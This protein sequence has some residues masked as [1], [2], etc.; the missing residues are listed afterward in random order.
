[1]EEYFLT[2]NNGLYNN[3]IIPDPPYFT[4]HTITTT[5]FIII[6]PTHTPCYLLCSIWQSNTPFLYERDKRL[7]SL[8]LLSTSSVVSAKRHSRAAHPPILH[9]AAAR[10][11]ILLTPPFFHN[12]R[13]PRQ[14]YC[15]T[16]AT[17]DSITAMLNLYTPPMST[18]GPDQRIAYHGYVL[19][20][21][22]REHYLE[23]RER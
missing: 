2:P 4:G 17:Q 11:P 13:H 16:A 6:K 21:K 3:S 23:L 5:S 19:G 8:T 20:A 14:H 12:C 18:T 15:H 22:F 1:M 7:H 9:S 10:P